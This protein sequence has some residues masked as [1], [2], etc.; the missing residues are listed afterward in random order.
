M[1]LHFALD[2]CFPAGEFLTSAIGETWKETLPDIQLI[3][4]TSHQIL[5]EKIFGGRWVR[6]IYTTRWGQWLAPKIAR[7]PWL[8]RVYALWQRQRFTRRKIRPFVESFELDASE[9]ACAIEK[10]KSFND[11]FTR[12]L[13]PKAR[14]IDPDVDAAILPADGRYKFYENIEE[15]IPLFVKGN[16]LSIASLL[17]SDPQ[18]TKYLGGTLILARLSPV[19]CHRFFAP[20]AGRISSPVEI[21]GLL[22]SV[23]PLATRRKGSIL[24][25]N[26]RVLMRMHTEMF[27]EILLIAIGATCVGSIHATYSPNEPVRRGEEI[28]YYSFGG[29]A[30]AL[31][32]QS[33][34]LCLASDLEK[35]ARQPSEIYCQ[36]GQKLGTRRAR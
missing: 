2:H 22:Y 5:E 11:F 18:C 21:P 19:D 17:A 16:T 6:L 15:D 29:S 14:P 1:F 33:G 24:A 36:Y 3:D 28:G 9:F 34:A 30:F 8:S 27:G 20:A 10:F 7:W 4:R 32:F 25:R 13:T 12:K 26:R 35:L 31:L 23:N